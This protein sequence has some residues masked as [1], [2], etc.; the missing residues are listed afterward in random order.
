[1]SDILTIMGRELKSYFLSPV[2]YVLIALYAFLT[3]AVFVFLDVFGTREATMSSDFSWMVVLA[4]ILAPALAMRLFAE[5][6]R[7]GTIELLMTAPVRDWQIVI[8]K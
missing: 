8:G 7:Q 4:L 2:A 5:E 1:M 6:N 3:G